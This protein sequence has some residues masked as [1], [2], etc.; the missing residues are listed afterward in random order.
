MFQ[1]NK[2]ELSMNAKVGARRWSKEQCGRKEQGKEQGEEQVAMWD[3][4]ARS[5]AMSE[6]KGKEQVAS[7]NDQSRERRGASNKEQGKKQGEEQEA[8]S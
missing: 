4:G 2:C 7:S 8:R 1:R 6:E 3:R 5:K